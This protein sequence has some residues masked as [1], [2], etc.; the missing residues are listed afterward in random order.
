MRT[1]IRA[2]LFDYSGVIARKRQ[3][4]KE[5]RGQIERDFGIDSKALKQELE[6]RGLD[7][8]NSKELGRVIHVPLKEAFGVELPDGWIQSRLTKDLFPEHV[9]L[10]RGLRAQYKTAVVA[11]SDGTLESR[12]REQGIHGLFDVVIDSAVVGIRKPEAGIFLTAAARLGL[13]PNACLFI[14]DKPEN[15][16]GAERL[17]MRGICFNLECGESL[18]RM[19]AERGV[20]I[21]IAPSPI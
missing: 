4:L 15:V 6:A 5:L 18:E 12:M 13:N 10:V 2:V 3:K 9:S 20:R 14:D 11:N 7:G 1:D 17:G 8:L 16:R 19:L 21:M